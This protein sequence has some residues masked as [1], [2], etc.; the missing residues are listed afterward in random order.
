MVMIITKKKPILAGKTKDP[1]MMDFNFYSLVEVSYFLRRSSNKSEIFK[2][3]TIAYRKVDKICIITTNSRFPR[4][5][6]LNPILFTI[7]EL[8]NI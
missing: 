4:I 2:T 3:L 5:L 7:E 6:L 8:Y 1:Y